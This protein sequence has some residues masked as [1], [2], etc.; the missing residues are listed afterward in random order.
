MQE[1]FTN[2]AKIPIAMSSVK[3]LS[4]YLSL[5]LLSGPCEH[6]LQANISEEILSR[7]SWTPEFAEFSSIT[8]VLVYFQERFIL[9][10]SLSIEVLSHY[11]YDPIDPVRKLLLRVYSHFNWLE[12]ILHNNGWVKWSWELKSVRIMWS[13][14]PNLL[15]LRR[16]V[17]NIYAAGGIISNLVN[18]AYKVS[19]G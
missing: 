5:I 4:H 1:I 18:T 16:L 19:N 3:N 8:V 2:Y 15:L 6:F 14:W 11:V 10:K 17:S 7:N 13:Y 12:G 9:S